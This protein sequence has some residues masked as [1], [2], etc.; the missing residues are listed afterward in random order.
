MSAQSLPRAGV[1]VRVGHWTDPRGWTGCTVVL[2]PEGTVAGAEVRGGA[3]AT[4]ELELLDPQRSVQR[5]DAILLTGGSAFGLAAA[6]GVMRYCEERG[7]GF[8]TVAGV[9]PIVPALAIFDLLEGGPARPGAAEGYAACEAAVEADVALGRVGAGAA[10]TIAKWRGREH[11]RPAGI[12]GARLDHDGLEVAALVVVN[13]LGDLRDPAAPPR[14]PPAIASTRA[15]FG[16]TTVGAI[17]TNAT[18][19]KNECQQ[20][21][22]SG[23]VGM[24]RALDPVHTAA[25][26]DALVVAATGFLEAG[27]EVVRALAAAAVEQA[28]LTQITN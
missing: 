16:N 28:I 27:L 7:M 15:A 26:G 10:A 17:I 22:V 20:V 19:S 25:D 8:P 13:A 1:G 12:G 6:D 18:L 5:A 21:A 9:V 3:P 11:A 24:A 2:L 4:R 14:I 23:H